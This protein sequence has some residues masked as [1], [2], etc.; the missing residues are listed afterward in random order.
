MRLSI[1]TNFDHELVEQ[2][3]DYPVTELFGKLRTDTVGGGRAPYQ[4]AKVSRRQLA[5]HVKHVRNSGMTFNY[6]LN[7]S[8]MGN[9]EIT[10]KG[11]KELNKL[12]DWIGDIGVT[13]VTVAS[14]F[15][16][17]MIKAR[18]PHLSRPGNHILMCVSQSLAE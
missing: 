7:A 1:A 13:A 3:R 9:R 16:L 15:M 17:Q 6:L 8:C 5:D 14:P 2:C 11:Q 18:Q 4:L 10:R 12:L